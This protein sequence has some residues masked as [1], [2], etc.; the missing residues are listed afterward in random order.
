MRVSYRHLF[1]QGKVLRALLEAGV[2]S[3]RGGGAKGEPTAPGPVIERTLPPLA[4]SLIRDYVRH[5]GGN[6]DA[7]KNTVPP[8]LFPQWGFPLLSKTLQ[9]VPYDM[10]RVVNAGFRMEIRRALPADEPLRMKGNLAAIDDN[11]R[12]IIITERLITET[13]SAPDALLA[14][15]NALIPLKKPGEKSG[16]KKD[17][18]RVPTDVREIGRWRLGPN[19]GLEFA[20]LTGDFNPIHWIPA[21]AKAAGFR[22]TIL[23]G[24]STA[25]RAIETLN[26]ALWSGRVD[27]L[28]SW[29]VR[30]NRPLVLPGNVGVFVDDLGG[31]YIGDGPGGPSYLSGHYTIREQDD[32]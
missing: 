24:F 15:V 21:Y 14:E 29:D 1:R 23:H 25:A 12:R 17:K 18:P 13:D 9:A 22:N 32:E 20:F 10:S 7:Y 26:Q 11:G 30:F 28:K 3:A 2:L 19:A 27:Y 4:R 6:P 16:A 31:V 5:V 8:H